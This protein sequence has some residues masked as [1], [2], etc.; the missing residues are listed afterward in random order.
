M[1]R[2]LSNFTGRIHMACQI[3]AT[4]NRNRKFR[5]QDG[6]RRHANITRITI[7]QS[8]MDRFL[9]NLRDRDL[10]ACLVGLMQN[11][12]YTIINHDVS[13]PTACW[14]HTNCHISAIYWPN[15]YRNMVYWINMV[16]GPKT[17]NINS[18][19]RQSLLNTV[20]IGHQRNKTANIKWGGEMRKGHSGKIL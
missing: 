7:S 11:R 4:R 20:V 9:S 19:K 2:F 12:N 16:F 18:K 17:A 6:G 8:N 15:Q 3:A 14:I 1:H 5:I 13:R 10:T